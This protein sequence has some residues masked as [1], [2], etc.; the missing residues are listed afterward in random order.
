[1]PESREQ[2]QLRRLLSQRAADAARA[3]I[4]CVLVRRHRGRTLEAR[5]VEAEAYL[6]F[7][8]PAAHVYRGPTPRTQPLFGPPGTIYVYFVY[9]MH[10]CLN[11]SVDGPGTPGCV[12]IRAAEPLPGSGLDERSLSGPGRLCRALGIDTRLSGRHLFEPDAPLTLRAGAPPAKL[13]VTRRIGINVAQARRLRFCDPASP[14]VSAA[15][16]AGISLLPGRRRAKAPR[17]RLTAKR[18]SP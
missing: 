9:G 15:R 13:A 10:H 5:I 17:A 2:E 18:G 14:A 1:V 8:D 3:L 11:I 7:D 16:P 6:G 4:G 12:L